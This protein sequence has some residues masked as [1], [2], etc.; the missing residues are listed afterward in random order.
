MNSQLDITLDIALNV[1]ILRD[2]FDNEII[3]VGGGE[4]ASS[5]Y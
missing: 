1:E 3:L 4:S 5:L 2:L